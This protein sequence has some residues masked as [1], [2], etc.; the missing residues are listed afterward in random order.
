MTQL[1]LQGRMN[2]IHKFSQ[3]DLGNQ[4]L[5]ISLQE[6]CQLQRAQVSDEALARVEGAS[7][8]SFTILTLSLKQYTF[9]EERVIDLFCFQQSINGSE[10]SSH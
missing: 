1:K 5:S 9:L 7:I 6:F 4:G 2:C 10:K 8:S 3:V